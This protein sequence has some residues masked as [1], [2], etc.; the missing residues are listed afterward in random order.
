MFIPRSLKIHKCKKC[1]EKLIDSNFVKFGTYLKAGKF[2]Y[3]VFFEYQCPHCQYEG[4]WVISP[5]KGD[6]PGDTFRQFGNALDAKYF[7]EAEQPSEDF[8]LEDL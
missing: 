5:K 7:Q 1:K 2:Q 6:L 3:Y 8:R 4:A